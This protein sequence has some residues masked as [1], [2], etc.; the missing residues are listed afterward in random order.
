MAGVVTQAQVQSYRALLSEVETAA[1]ADVFELV[2]QANRLGVAAGQQLLH[3]LL[4]HVLDP[5]AVVSSEVAAAFYEELRAAAGVA[6]SYAVEAL[7]AGL[8]DRSVH[9][10]VGEAAKRADGGALSF[11]FL[12]GGVAKRVTE[13]A[14][15]TIIGNA[16]A[17]RVMVG[18][19]RVPQA[20]C[21]AFCG[22]LASRGAAYG[23]AESAGIVVG[24]GRPVGSHRLAKGI[25]PRG[26]RKLGEAFHDHCRCAVV[27]V[28]EDTHVEMQARADEY[29]DAYSE[30]YS[31][32]RDGL[33][34]RPGKKA[35]EDEPGY[36]GHWARSGKQV[37]NAQTVAEI[38]SF[39]RDSLGVK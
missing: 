31:K 17:D 30:A 36:A 21:C 2:Q 14:S 16:A 12:A 8:A 35:T 24:R 3:E 7:P 18:Y 10:L 38:L 9:S 23:S 37:T 33:E 32:A 4:P 11:E 19:Q 25:R 13:V 29:Y 15:D 22:M 27:P 34:W 28:F 6:Q 26:S 20:G 39:M 5:Y 1:L